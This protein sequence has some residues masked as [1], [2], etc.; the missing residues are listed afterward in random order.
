MDINW[1]QIISSAVNA[2]INGVAVFMSVK[3]TS[4]LFD[5]IDRKRSD[6]KEAQ[7]D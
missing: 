4:R 7:G 5:K 1:T 6:K 3:V 2:A